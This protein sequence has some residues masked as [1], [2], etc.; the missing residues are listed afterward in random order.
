MKEI[1]KTVRCYAC[2]D[3]RAKVYLRPFGRTT[4]GEPK[5]WVCDGC[6]QRQVLTAASP[7]GP[8]ITGKAPI[9]FT[10]VLRAERL[11]L[12]GHAG[13]ADDV[14][15]NALDLLEGRLVLRGKGR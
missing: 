3:E 10:T 2:G 11:A 8:R 7:S 13:T 4:N 12:A 1:N 15:R 6:D 5:T 9:K 14:L